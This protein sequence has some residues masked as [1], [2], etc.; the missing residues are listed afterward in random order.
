MLE[1]CIQAAEM[2][3]LDAQIRIG[4]DSAFLDYE[5]LNEMLQIFQDS[6]GV[7]KSLEYLS[8]SMD[9]TF[10]L[11]LDAD[12]ITTDCLTKVDQKTL[13]LSANERLT[14]EQNVVPYIHQHQNEFK[15]KNFSQKEDLS[16]LRWTL[17][18]PDD[19]KLVKE[20]YETLY[21]HNPD[22]VMRDI[23]ELIQ[24]RPEL[25]SINSKVIPRTGYWSFKEKVKLKDKVGISQRER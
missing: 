16:H 2:F 6:Y 7:G 1:R 23:L 15:C 4:A 14:N 9:R 18:T 19:W 5:V 11:G 12:F 10:P 24:E 13:H 20:V 17:D 22:F 25:E 3:D 21:P 8:N